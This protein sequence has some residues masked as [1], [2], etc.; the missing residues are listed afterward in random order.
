MAKQNE[1]NQKNEPQIKEW[2]ELNIPNKRDGS[3]E[4]GQVNGGMNE[5]YQPTRNENPN[6]PGTE[7]PTENE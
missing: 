5:G 1:S 7:N 4:K 3:V 2:I 6:P